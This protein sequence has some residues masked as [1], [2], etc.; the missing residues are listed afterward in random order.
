MYRLF[1]LFLVLISTSFVSAA[2]VT[3]VSPNNGPVAGG[4][5]VSII[6][7]GFTGATAVQFGT[8]PALSF[9]VNSDSLIT[10]LAPPHVF[11]IVNVIVTAPSG[12]ST[13]TLA[14]RYVYQGTWTAYVTNQS[15][16][17]VTPI[18]IPA[19]VPGTPI[20]VGGDPVD[21]AI[22]P[23]G[24][25]AYVTN[26]TLNRVDVI[27][28]L[29][30][31]LVTSI[32]V[33]TA[34]IGIA[35]TPDGQKVFVSNSG[36]NTI[37]IILTSTNSV[38]Q[39]LSPGGSPF[40]V[41]ITPDGTTAYF[42]VN[43][44]TSFLQPIN[45]TTFAGG[46]PISLGVVTASFIAMNPNG[47]N[48]YV[49]RQSVG[50][51]FVINIPSGTVAGTISFPGGTA[52][53]RPAVAPNGTIGYVTNLGGNGIFPLNLIS[54]TSG[55]NVV[56]GTAPFGLAITPDGT[57]VYVGNSAVSTV[58]PVDIATNTAGAPIVVPA[59]PSSVAITPDQA[60]LATFVASVG[61]PGT[62]TLFDASA[63][64]SP[65]GTIVSYAW[66]FGD[67]Q[68]AV[69]TSPFI[70]HTYAAFGVY[71]VTLIVTNSAGT[72]TFQTFP[73]ATFLQNGNSNAIFIQSISVS[74]GTPPL[75]PSNF[76]GT[77]VK[78]VFATQTDIINH[79]SWDPSPDP[80]IISYL[81][82]RNG[83]LIARICAQGPFIFNDHNRHKN[84]IDT[85]TLTAF[86]AG[87][88]STPLT[89]TIP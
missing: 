85:Y 4:N 86:S 88:E 35:I 9:T 43:A 61:P 8:S 51:L 37:S 12:T 21:I 39:V 84:E 54:N 3:D 40:G 16:G 32:P 18:S 41:A 42:V 2:L 80:A 82:R 66:D 59:G 76:Q 63:S 29:T 55:T 67:G 25:F 36:S 74:A 45:T 15:T 13:V 20:T 23:D 31:T 58:S 28:L 52:P 70:T 53:F 38:I 78:N 19:N 30:N 46:A 65:V 89:L 64:A 72:S 60:P 73:G 69:T 87:G 14:D 47:Q 71:N 24:Q 34:P 7:S 83:V 6:G 49:G 1:F 33:G 5:P 11:G 50:P 56:T 68:T 17:Q 27:N 57:T 62:A 81:I 79:L 10:A 44:A 26:N 75:P 48:A 22:T 77:V